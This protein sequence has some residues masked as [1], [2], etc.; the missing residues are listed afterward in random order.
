VRGLRLVAGTL[1]FLDEG[2]AP[3]LRVSPPYIVGADGTTFEAA[4]ALAAARS[5][6][7]RPR[8]GV[9]R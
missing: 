4:L 3:R 5:I 2:G 7:T 8:R 9:G 6:T 1:E